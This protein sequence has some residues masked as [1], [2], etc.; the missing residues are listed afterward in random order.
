LGSILFAAALGVAA[1]CSDSEPPDV[2][3]YGPPNG[4]T[5]QTPNPPVTGGSGSGSGGGTTPEDAGTT[6]TGDGG[7]VGT[8]TTTFACQTAGGTIVDGGPCSVSW[9]QT[10]Y[11]AM[12]ATGA[13][14][15]A[16]TGAC[17]GGTTKPVLTGTTASSFYTS[18]AN[19]TLVPG[20]A[21]PYFNPCSTD[22][23]KSAF[24][25]SVSP[26]GTC[27]SLMPL[28]GGVGAMTDAGL[29]NIATWVACGS[30]QN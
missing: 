25:C 6:P 27:G 20:N 30:P 4:I 8:P 29:A 5:G 12:Q 11:P 9:S 2:P 26:T 21:N 10:I 17:H 16:A 23:T 18:L 7:T 1:A 28:A 14:G 22:P 15:C 13:W 19:Y 3:N 24:L